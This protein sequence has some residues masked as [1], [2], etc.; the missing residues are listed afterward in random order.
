[1]SQFSD[2]QTLSPRCLHFIGSSYRILITRQRTL[3]IRTFTQSYTM[4][5][6]QNKGKGKAVDVA[7]KA[8]TK[9]QQKK[10][11]ARTAKLEAREAKRVQKELRQVCVEGDGQLQRL[12]T[13][14]Q[15]TAS[16]RGGG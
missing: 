9:A 1:M 10:Q 14:K 16:K 15:S 2:A 4:A 7:P 11:E 3:A 6:K 5:P 12:I 8:M 13:L